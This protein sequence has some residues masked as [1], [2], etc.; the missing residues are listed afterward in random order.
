[1][2]SGQ[3]VDRLWHHLAPLLNIE[4]LAIEIG[5]EQANG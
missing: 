3:V 5:D 1:M 2:Q 4:L